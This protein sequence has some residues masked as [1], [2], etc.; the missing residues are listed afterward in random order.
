MVGADTTVLGVKDAYSIAETDFVASTNG[1]KRQ[2]AGRR[3]FY[4]IVH[5]WID[6]DIEAKRKVA[7]LLSSHRCNCHLRQCMAQ[8]AST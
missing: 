1:K 6:I 8:S 2:A 4:G 7:G 3:Q 5:P